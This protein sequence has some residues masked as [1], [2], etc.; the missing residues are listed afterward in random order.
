MSIMAARR[1]RD[2]SKSGVLF[3][4]EHVMA[5][6][7]PAPKQPAGEGDEVRITHHIGNEV[8]VPITDRV[9]VEST[10]RGVGEVLVHGL[11]GR[12]VAGDRHDH[13]RGISEACREGQ[14]GDDCLAEGCRGS[15][16][17]KRPWRGARSWDRRGGAPPSPARVAGYVGAGHLAG[18]TVL[19]PPR[20]RTGTCAAR[21]VQ[22]DP[23]LLVRPS[24][25]GFPACAQMVVRP[26]RP[27]LLTRRTLPMYRPQDQVPN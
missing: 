18:L 9:P 13:I 20:A 1:P 19:D 7:V 17:H 22:P 14:S 5:G 21:S 10:E 3:Q 26:S 16:C 23:G 15:A 4:V 27:P 8:V 2:Q 24:A 11:P 12:L 6:G 25:P